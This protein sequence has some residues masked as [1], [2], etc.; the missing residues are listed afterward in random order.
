M[1]SVGADGV[2]PY[3]YDEDDVEWFRRF[4]LVPVAPERVRRLFDEDRVIETLDVPAYLGR[5]LLVDVET[6]TAL[7]RLIQLFGTP[8]VSGLEAG[9]EM[10]ER[11]RTTWQYLFEARYE[12]PDGDERTFYLSLYDH[13][14]DVSVGLSTVTGPEPDADRRVREPSGEPPSGLDVPD[15]EFLVGLVQLGLN[16]LEEPVPA[17]YKD[18]WV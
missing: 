10:P 17:T 16:V 7:Y 3:R 11:E 14:T 13:K 4:D 18:L 9:A 2:D 1:V 8:N 5:P 6:G 15:E 12:P